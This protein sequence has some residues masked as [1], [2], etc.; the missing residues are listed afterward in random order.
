MTISHVP[1]N[2]N[3][4]A[5]ELLEQASRFCLGSTEVNTRDIAKAQPEETKDWRFE[6][7]QYLSD[8]S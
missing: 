3:E 5:N 1:P 8:P 4:V 6:L 2:N 7:K